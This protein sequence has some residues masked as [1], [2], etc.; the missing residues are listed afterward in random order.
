MAV[1]LAIFRSSVPSVV[2]KRAKE[3]L[4]VIREAVKRGLGP[5]RGETRLDEDQNG[6]KEGE[7]MKIQQASRD[8]VML[9]TEI[10]N[11]EQVNVVESTNIW[12]RSTSR[13][14]LK[15]IYVSC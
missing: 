1:L 11:L 4:G 7:Q 12:G 8:V 6:S 13:F 2:K 5:S 10:K 15:C 9:D 14:L 3:L